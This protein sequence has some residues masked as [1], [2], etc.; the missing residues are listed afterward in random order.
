M[1]LLPGEVQFQ[2]MSH[3]PLYHLPTC[4]LGSLEISLCLLAS[5]SG[6]WKWKLQWATMSSPNTSISQENKQSNAI[7][8]VC[9]WGGRLSC[10]LLVG[11]YIS[12]I[13]MDNSVGVPQRTKSNIT[14]HSYPLIKMDARPRDSV[15]P[16]CLFLW[17]NSLKKKSSVGEEVFIKLIITV[18]SPSLWES[19]GTSLKQLTTLTDKCRKC[20]C[21]C[22]PHQLLYSNPVQHPNPKTAGHIHGG[23]SGP[24]LYD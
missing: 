4:S 15:L 24:T 19:R 16:L 8:D 17:L 9:V 2:M 10:I 6:E 5:L 20:P 12:K 14:A 11:V 23:L 21:F 18:Y 3:L 7:K 13:I 1:E 22:C